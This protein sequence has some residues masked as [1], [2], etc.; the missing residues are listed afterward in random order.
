MTDLNTIISTV[1]YSLSSNIRSDYKLINIFLPIIITLI[2][3]FI[4]KNI[5]KII[6]YFKGNNYKYKQVITYYSVLQNGIWVPENRDPIYDNYKHYIFESIV[7]YITSKNINSKNCSV[8]SN[9]FN[10]SGNALYNKNI[11]YFETIKIPID[12]VEIEK[13]I[14]IKFSCCVTDEKVNRAKMTEICIASNKSVNV[15]DTFIKKCYDIKKKDV[16]DKIEQLTQETYFYTPYK[17]VNNN[18]TFKKYKYNPTKN[19]DNIITPNIQEIKDLIDDFVNKKN[20]YSK[21]IIT[22]KLTLLLYGEA[23]TGKSSLI[24]AISKC[25]KRSIIDVRLSA[26][27]TN[28]QLNDI[29]YS[30]KIYVMNDKGESVVD[31]I[32][33]DKIIYMLEEIDTIDMCT[34][35]VKIPFKKKKIDKKDEE[36]EEEIDNLNLGTLLTIFDGTMNTNNRIMLITTNKPELLDERLIRPGR[37]T[38]QLYFTYMTS[39]CIYKLLEKYYDCELDNKIQIK[40]KYTPAQIEQMC[41]EYKNVNDLLK[42]IVK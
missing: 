24:Q 42:N 17:I 18:V 15:I 22:H 12:F 4:G 10:Y 14:Y 5:T 23:G 31:A 33:N 39:D 26:F 6:N 20:M 1:G 19:L 28:Q 38:K 30:G 8:I 7:D 9:S 35:V 16:I 2:L 21:Q 11:K 29:F 40:N 37:I 32:D 3:T 13:N 36:E 27:K 25:T 34:N 41:F